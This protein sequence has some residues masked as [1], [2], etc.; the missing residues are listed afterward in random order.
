MEWLN[1]HHLLYFWTVAKEGSIARACEKLRLAQP[2]ISGQL[3]VLEETLGEKLFRKRGRG[4][5]LTEIGQLVFEYAEEIFGLGQELQTV[6]KGRPRDRPLR[7]VIGV[8]DLVPKLIAYRV[9]RTAL[10]MQQPVQIVCDEGAP[11]HLLAEL[12]EH[13]IDAVLSDAPIPP[14]IPVKAFNHLLG[15]STIILFSTRE[16][17]VRYR[18]NFPASLDRAPFLLPMR[19]SSLRGSLEQWFDSEKI[20]PHLI[21]EFKDKALMTTFGQGGAGIFAAPA[22]IEKEIRRQYGVVVIGR[23]DS[24][25]ENYY[26]ISAERKVRHPAVVAI[27]EA[28]RQRLF[29]SRGTD[30]R[31]SSSAGT[32]GALS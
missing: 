2:T 8:S 29:A 14:A 20:R 28:A 18:K 4:L 10:K 22:V 9:L 26:I 30:D 6:L 11:E 25:V 19:G 1:Y 17:A 32:A 3:R 12:A 24:I 21:G 16:L 31:F 23:I 7:L 5:A 15:S 13:R 27:S